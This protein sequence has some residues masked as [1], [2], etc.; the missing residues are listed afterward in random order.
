MAPWLGHGGTAGA[1]STV[2]NEVSSEVG[3]CS[4]LT[5][6]LFYPD[7]ITGKVGSKAKTVQARSI[8]PQTV[9]CHDDR[10]AREV[11]YRWL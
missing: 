11:C 3:S 4:I 5:R 1:T 6:L 8:S 10:E 7:Q 9:F 2:G